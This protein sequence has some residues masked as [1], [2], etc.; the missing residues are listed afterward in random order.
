ML[1]QDPN[2]PTHVDLV[3][4]DRMLE[5]LEGVVD[6]IGSAIVGAFSVFAVEDLKPRGVDVDS[7]AEDQPREFEDVDSFSELDDA[8]IVSLQPLELDRAVVAQCLPMYSDTTTAEL[9]DNYIHVVAD[10]LQPAHHTQ[11]PYLSLYVPKAMEAAA[12]GLFIGVGVHRPRLGQ[13]SSTLSSLYP[14]STCIA[15]GRSKFDIIG[16]GGCTD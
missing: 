1:I 13:R 9:M 8:S 4:I 5:E 6:V 14:H 15:I 16:K 3:Q 2:L 7:V 10:L 12:A 11:N